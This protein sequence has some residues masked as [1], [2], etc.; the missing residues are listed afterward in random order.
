MGKTRSLQCKNMKR[1]T[2]NLQQRLG[3]TKVNYV[4]IQ[5]SCMAVLCAVR[6][7]LS[8]VG[9]GIQFYF[10]LRAN[11]VL[12]TRGNVHFAGIYQEV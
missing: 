10:F 4:A 7:L 11:I 2:I 9:F 3:K 8:Q 5:D 1:Q 6:V 12:D